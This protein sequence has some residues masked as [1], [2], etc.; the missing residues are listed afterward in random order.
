MLSGMASPVCTEVR[1][2]MIED[3]RN[4]AAQQGGCCIQRDALSSSPIAADRAYGIVTATRQCHGEVVE[5]ALLLQVQETEATRRQRGSEHTA[6]GRELRNGNISEFGE[7]VLHHAIHLVTPGG[8]EAWIQ[9]TKE[10]D[11]LGQQAEA[12][13]SERH[14]HAS[15]GED[16]RKALS[17]AEA[18]LEV[19]ETIRQKVCDVLVGARG[20]RHVARGVRIRIRKRLAHKSEAIT[21]GLRAPAPPGW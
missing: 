16:S 6:C 1:F 21:A 13:N 8:R 11:I 18:P 15:V 17:D 20:H 4:G 14:M 3:R 9:G 10:V 7:S 19:K 2:R 12:N 5:A